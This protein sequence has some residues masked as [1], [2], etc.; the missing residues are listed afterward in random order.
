MEQIH[1]YDYM[2]SFQIC[3][4]LYRR[5]GGNAVEDLIRAPHSRESKAIIRDTFQNKYMVFS[6]WDHFWEWNPQNGGNFDEVIF[7]QNKQKIKFDIDATEAKLTHISTKSLLSLQN[8]YNITGYNKMD[9][10]MLAL[11]ELIQ[12]E[13]ELCYNTTITRQDLVVTD[14]SGTDGKDYKY[15]YHIVLKSYVVENNIETAGFTKHIIEKLPTD[16]Q[17][18]IDPMVNKRCQCFRLTSSTKPHSKRIKQ[19]TPKYFTSINNDITLSQIQSS[20]LPMLTSTFQETSKLISPI[21]LSSP[22]IQQIVNSNHISQYSA[23]KFRDYKNGILLFSRLT[24]SYCNI[25]AR[26]HDNDNSLMIVV[27]IKHISK[28]PHMSSTYELFEHCRRSIEKKSIL[29]GDIAMMTTNHHQN[30]TYQNLYV[31]KL[32][33]DLKTGRRTPHYTTKF[34]SLPNAMIYNSNKMY[35]YNNHPTLAVKGGMKIGKTKHLRELLDRNYPQ[36]SISPAIIRMISF[37]R[38]FA[39]AAHKIFNEFHIYSSSRGQLSHSAHP[40]L[41]IQVESLHRLDFGHAPEPVDLIILDECESI[42]EQF[43]SG[44]S[45][46]LQKA[47]TIFEWMVATA[48]RLICIDAD[49]SNRSYNF[50]QSVRPYYP[51]YYHWNQYQPAQNNIYYCTSIRGR[52]LEHL[53]YKLSSNNRLVIATNS[54]NEAEILNEFVQKTFPTLSVQLYT[55]HT[56]QKEIHFAKIDHYWSKLDV[57]IYT[58]TISAGLSYEGERFDCLFGFFTD[59]SC[60]V[61]ICRQM[62]GRVRSINTYYI[63]LQGYLKELPSTT[64]QIN[65]MINF[66]QHQLSTDG[67]QLQYVTGK[68]FTAQKSHFYKLWLDNIKLINLSKNNFIARFLDQIAETGATLEYLANSPYHVPELRQ[69]YQNNK[70][71]IISNRI[72]AIVQAPDITDEQYTNF[73]QS[74]LNHE[75][76]SCSQWA[77]LQ[78]N[79]LQ[80]MFR[81]HERPVSHAFVKK[82]FRPSV[83]TLYKNLTLILSA[84]TV[85][86]SLSIL[87]ND[88]YK[89]YLYLTDEF[90]TI[91]HEI[92][93]T[94]HHLALLIIKYFHFT[95]LM[96]PSFTTNINEDKEPLLTELVKNF[97]INLALVTKARS[98]SMESFVKICNSVLRTMYGVKIELTTKGFSLNINKMKKLFTILTPTE[99]INDDTKPYIV[100]HLS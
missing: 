60:N 69:M 96:D 85:W 54:R 22:D 17:P 18:L 97:Q 71:I 23:F 68:G 75:Q 93:F 13:I 59:Y 29:I 78:K 52:W 26:M 5:D 9:L 87:K 49:L 91:Q 61:E 8:Q 64:K 58:P 86:N 77:M 55:G 12:T 32:I 82:Y 43:N 36:D 34:E 66:N 100:S 83:I 44:L 51:I 63:Y 24:P 25:C 47:F 14:S 15:S 7:G 65:S 72:E 70:Q 56:P 6:S 67:L 76:L 95:C 4:T 46:K 38:T 37:R 94:K 16:V 98:G 31:Q 41:I 19:E 10:I 20:A 48:H 99:Q 62:I 45:R 1:I 88:E 89:F 27:K 33:L 57:L 11:I 53:Y 81:W 84:S 90:Q 80:H 50:L 92:Q 30:L 74:L 21:Q 2:M 40:R 35:K 3:D 73:R 28:D 42:L 79:K 39:S